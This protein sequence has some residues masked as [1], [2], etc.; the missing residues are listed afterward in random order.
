MGFRFTW[1]PSKGRTNL[2]KHGVAFE[3]ASTVFADALSLTIYDAAHSDA[4]DRWLIIGISQHQQLL[5]VHTDRGDT[6][7]IISARQAT[8]AKGECMS[9]VPETDA[10]YDMLDEYD[11]SQGVQGKYAQRYAEG[12]NVIVLAPDVADVFPTQKP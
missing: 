10:D 4:K 7:R 6:I 12:T 9:N 11:F 5:V 2:E 1:D 3:E 8:P